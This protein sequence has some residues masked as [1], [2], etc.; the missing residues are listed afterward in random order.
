M[1]GAPAE[2]QNG[3]EPFLLNSSN[4][5]TGN[6][7]EQSETLQKKQMVDKNSL[8]LN[9]SDDVSKVFVLTSSSP[10]RRRGTTG[11]ISHLCVLYSVR[12]T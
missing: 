1:R 6:W 4:S 10:E 3:L 11:I 12:V 7:S 8:N 9:I 2:V 5:F